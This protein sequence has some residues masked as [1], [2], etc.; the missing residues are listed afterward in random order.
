MRVICA[1][2]KRLLKDGPLDGL[3]SHG[4]C[5]ACLE[6]ELANIDPRRT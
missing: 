6:R 2:C 5:S 4:C 1:W 3:V